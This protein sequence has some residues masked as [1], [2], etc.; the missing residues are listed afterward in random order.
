VEPASQGPSEP[1]CLARGVD[2]CGASL[3][4]AALDGRTQPTCYLE[5]SRLDGQACTA[6]VQCA[7]GGCNVPREACRATPGAPCTAALGCAEAGGRRHVCADLAGQPRCQPIGSGE[8]GSLCG[9]DGDCDEGTCVEGTCAGTSVCG[10]AGTGPCSLGAE[11][12]CR[13]CRFRAFHQCQDACQATWFALYDCMYMKGCADET[14]HAEVCPDAY[15][16]F[17]ECARGACSQHHVCD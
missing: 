4:C 12:E 13:S 10:G 3:F 1:C 14:C 8:L 5:R 11:Q 7:S 17:H 6:D 16:A 9:D 2:A 15:C